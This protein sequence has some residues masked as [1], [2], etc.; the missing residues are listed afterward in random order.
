MPG[1]KMKSTASRLPE[2]RNFEALYDQI[3]VRV[4]LGDKKLPLE[5]WLFC[6]LWEWYRAGDSRI[7]Q[8]YE[9][10]SR[11]QFDQISRAFDRLALGELTDRYREGMSVWEDAVLSAGLTKWMVDHSELI[12]Q[13]VSSLWAAFRENPLHES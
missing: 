6:R 2:R 11:Q 5:C 1:T 8:Y 4:G 10:L 7:S 13:T 9:G 12:E 3:T